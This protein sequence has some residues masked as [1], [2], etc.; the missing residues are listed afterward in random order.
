M[1]VTRYLSQYK[2][3]PS[4]L[5]LPPPEGPN[6][7]YLVIQD[8]D[9]VGTTCFGLCKDTYIREMPFPQDKRLTVRYSTGVGKNERTYHDDVF[10]IPALNQPLS[11][12]RYYVIKAHGRHKGEAYASSNEDDKVTCCFFDCTTDVKPRELDYEDIYQQIEI[13]AF[14]SC[15][16]PSGYVAKSVAQDGFPP[17]F[18]AR[19]GWEVNTSTP[20][21]YQL[22]EAQGINAS[23]R[24]RLPQFDFPLSSKT[25]GTVGVGKW[26][27][28]FVFIKEEGKLKDQMKRSMFYE[29]KLEQQWKQIYESENNLND[30]NFV[31]VDVSVQKE[32]ALLFG[33]EALHNH[34]Q[35]T[36][37]VIWFSNVNGGGRGG[38][39]GES[40]V[41]LSSAIVERMRW[42]Q[43]RVGWV[44]GGEKQ[45][46]VER[47]EEFQGGNNGWKKYGC[48][49]FVERF[50]FTRMDGSLLLTYE[51]RHAH[52][53]RSKWE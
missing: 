13:T 11:S 9:S 7:G 43:E 1:Y 4:S 50:V 23:L 14:E 20:R 49:I 52:Q 15:L 17:R 46:R 32:V 40:K 36:E 35:V 16:G 28:P 25:S 45:V 41:G 6:S 19:K 34:T 29:I 2:Q 44:G 39:V 22:C 48:Y 18:L 24:T 21:N 33:N 12:N 51:Y 37:G 30:H 5:S 53:I 26:Y 38:E 3:L 8:E 10:F 42:E 27:S 31:V 47:V